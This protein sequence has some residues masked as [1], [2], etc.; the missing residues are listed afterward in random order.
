MSMAALQKS[1]DELQASLD[2]AKEQI[3]Q[4]GGRAFGGFTEVIGDPARLHLRRTLS[5]LFLGRRI[6]GVS[7][8][9]KGCP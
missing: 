3:A 2:A 8:G 9:T 5:L 4:G 1:K 6:G 7:R